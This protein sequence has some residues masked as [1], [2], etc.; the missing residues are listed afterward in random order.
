MTPSLGT[1]AVGCEDE[2]WPPAKGVQDAGSEA[3][4]PEAGQ[5]DTPQSFDAGRDATIDAYIPPIRDS[6]SGDAFLPPASDAGDAGFADAAQPEPDCDKDDDG[7]VDIAC[8]HANIAFCDEYQP[9]MEI[10]E[11]LC[12]C[13]DTRAE[14][15]PVAGEICDGEDNNCDNLVDN[16]DVCPH[17]EC[18]EDER[19]VSDM[20]AVGIC[21]PEIR[22][23]ENGV[24]V[25]RQ[26]ERSPEEEIP[27]NGVDEDCNGADPTGTDRDGDGFRTEGGLC[28]PVD[29][30]DNERSINPQSA[31]RCNGRNDNCIN[32]VDEGFDIGDICEVGV[33]ECYNVGQKICDPNGLVTLCNANPLPPSPE[34][35][36]NNM[37][38][39]CDGADFTGTD[40]DGDGFKTEGGLCGPIDCNDGERG[41]NPQAVE[42]CNGR[43]DNCADGVD[44]GF[45]IG[46]VCEVGV[47]AC[48]NQGQTV[49]APD[50]ASAVCNV[51]PLN[52]S[53][54]I[55][56][57]IDDDCNGAVDDP[58][59]V[60]VQFSFFRTEGRHIVND[61]TGERTY[62]R[63]FNMPGLEFG[64]FE[65]IN[66]NNQ[67]GNNPYPGQ[68]GV[69]FFQL[70]PED[71]NHIRSLG[72]DLIR[73]PFEWAR[74]VPNWEPGRNVRL[75][76]QYLGLLDNT[77]RMARE[78]GL[79]T[80]LEMHDFLTY[81][82]APGSRVCVDG[83]EQPNDEYV[84]FLGET[85][86]QLAS[87]FAN[88]PAVLGYD[89]MNEPKR[90]AGNEER[91]Q[92]HCPSCNWSTEIAQQIVGAIRT[93]DNQHLIIVEGRN[94]SLASHWELENGRDAFVEDLI[95][96][97]RI[98]YSPHSYWDPGNDSH[99]N[100]APLVPPAGWQQI[101]RD[102]V[103][104]SIEW[105]QR[106]NVPL[107]M[108]EIGVPCSAQWAGTL[109]Y[110]FSNFFNPLKISSTYWF[111]RSAN[112]VNEE[113]NAATCAG[114]HQINAL[115]NHLGGIYVDFER[116]EP[117][118]PAVIFDDQE[119]Q[120][121][122]SVNIEWGA[123]INYCDNGVAPHNGRCAMS[124][125]FDEEWGGIKL[126][127]DFGVGSTRYRTL[128]FWVNGGPQGG[129][130]FKITTFYPEIDCESH[131]CDIFY[132]SQ[133]N[134]N[135]LC[136]QPATG[137]YEDRPNLSRYTGGALPPNQWVPVSIPVADI[138]DP[139]QPVMS[140]IAFQTARNPLP[141]KFH[142]DD[143]VL[144]P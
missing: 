26:R 24:W 10:S 34:V 78:R 1:V 110:T 63:G 5:L 77:V 66:Q 44:E 23:C 72:F 35:P 54:E 21:Q 29:C 2:A 114:D 129:Q 85:W 92:R 102:R 139:S 71:L 57:G 141:A 75:D 28:G 60:C 25:I 19:E 9:G 73:V 111:Y 91:C 52:P 76:P 86:S 27:C 144:M 8:R 103:L 40:R 3:G 107:Y 100:E 140:G 115:A 99:Y 93:V 13:D 101:I 47:G 14:I 135:G 133:E 55:C 120:T 97:P 122:T 64:Q 15:N 36:C 89:L 61:S 121:W 94:Y 80:V 125:Q 48:R 106:N 136:D 41:V 33:G 134:N 142:L 132:R 137:R 70:V 119:F 42:R 126:R 98:V 51:Q 4:R 117:E 88:E 128:D 104:S 30:D 96:P 79:Y 130:D 118:P 45:D 82:N 38:E 31:E 138:A 74:L 108:G 37:D 84:H 53:E 46:E 32:G 20:P 68:E 16:S 87:H 22:E 95:N 59:D 124:V 17:P 113:L 131:I 116:L 7:F 6:G 81:W 11:N 43:D 105:A 90:I 56:N 143:I 65:F 50:G 62:F 39:D 83:M 58:D 127:H 123:R 49:C 67:C 18:I 12:D 112:V 69:N 109:E